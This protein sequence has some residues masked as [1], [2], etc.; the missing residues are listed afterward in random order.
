MNKELIYVV[1]LYIFQT[2]LQYDSKNV[3]LMSELN[4][5]EFKYQGDTLTVSHFKQPYKLIAI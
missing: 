3:S 1:F 5:A 4:S 2:F